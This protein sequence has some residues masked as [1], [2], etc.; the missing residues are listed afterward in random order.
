MSDTTPVPDRFKGMTEE[1]IDAEL[2]YLSEDE[3][4]KLDEL[5]RAQS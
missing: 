2:G 4:E 3:R 5:M 1:Q